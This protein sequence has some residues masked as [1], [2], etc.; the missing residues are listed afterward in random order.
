M[1]VGRA[2]GLEE[3]HQLLAG[4]VLV[5]GTVLADDGEQMVHRLLA[6]AAGAER[7]GEIEAGLMVER[8]GGDLRFKLLHVAERA[9]GFLQL[10][11][12]AHGG[13]RAVIGGAGGREGKRRLGLF[14]IAGGELGAREADDGGEILG[15]LAKHGGEDFRRAGEIA[16]GQR[17]LAAGE[18][19]GDI[20][21]AARR[22]DE[23]VDDRLDL[24]FGLRAHEAVDRLAVDEGIDG[25]QR[26]DAELLGDGG[27]LVRVHLGE[28]DLA[29]G[30]AHHLLD[31]GG[32]LAAGAA[33]GRPEIDQHGAVA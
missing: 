20:V 24:G 30:R 13:D 25:G 32:E 16:L 18:D 8:V 3:L 10:D 27:V 22:R 31:D 7:H 4:A 1:I 26:L 9:G 15:L 2:P 28:A 33:P 11:G 5:P 17:R 21:A 19:V 6:L 14:E 12:G 23:L 29:L